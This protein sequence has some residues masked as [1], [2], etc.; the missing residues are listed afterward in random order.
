MHD[1]EF[2]P[3]PDGLPAGRLISPDFAAGDDAGRKVLWVSDEPSS[4]AGNLWCRLYDERARTGLYP[5]L[6]DT[7]RGDPERPWHAGELGYTPVE[8]IDRLD[9]LRVLQSLGDYPDEMFGPDELAAPGPAGEDPDENARMVAEAF[10][11]E[12]ARLLGLVPAVRGAD[13]L[14]LAGWEGPCNHTNETEWISAVVRSWEDRFGAR[15]VGV[16][17]A[18][19]WLSVAAP[20]VTIEHARAV[21]AEHMAFCP[22]NVWQGPGDFDVYA[23]G[24]AGRPAWR[25][26]WD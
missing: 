19:L 2:P 5:L 18:D 23:E 22:D 16:G 6:L 10:G 12:N 4:D 8:A 26:W 17:F 11:S 15:V 21:A 3:L 1:A 7:L 13:A 25:F 9:A 14:T 24:L 20:P